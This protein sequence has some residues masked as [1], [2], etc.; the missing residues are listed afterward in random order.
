MVSR[1]SMHSRFFSTQDDL[2]YTQTSLR[3]NG[4]SI[5]CRV[6]FLK[7]TIRMSVKFEVTE[8]KKAWS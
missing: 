5:E 3:K 1:S 2:Y 8:E 4:E 7:R 6:Y